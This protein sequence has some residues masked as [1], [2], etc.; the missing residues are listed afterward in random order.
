MSS[1]ENNKSNYSTI[2]NPSISSIVSG[3]YGSIREPLHPTTRSTKRQLMENT[4][5]DLLDKLDY[6]GYLY[7]ESRKKCKKLKNLVDTKNEEIQFLVN[8]VAALKKQKQDM[9]DDYHDLFNRYHE[10]KKSS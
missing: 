10:S 8:E 5:S 6:T 2:V 4:I 1:N 9:L 7:S 3:I